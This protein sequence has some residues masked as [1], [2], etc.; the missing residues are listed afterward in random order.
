MAEDAL[1]LSK[2]KLLGIGICY[3]FALSSAASNGDSHHNRFA[4]FIGL[5]LFPCCRFHPALGIGPRDR[6]AVIKRYR[7]DYCLLMGSWSS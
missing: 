5:L 7:N 2:A 3:N 4:S 1:I 6:D